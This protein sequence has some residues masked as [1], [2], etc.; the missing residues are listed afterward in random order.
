M[1]VLLVVK[2]K[3]KD[4]TVSEEKEHSEKIAPIIDSQKGFISK[5]WA[6]DDNSG[7]FA[8]VYEFETRAD[9]DAFLKS[10]IINGLRGSPFIIGNLD[11]QIYDIYRKQSRAKLRARDLASPSK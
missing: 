9:A 4:R 3:L 10:Q 7:K 8:G 2:F 11:S 5:I 6:G 1:P